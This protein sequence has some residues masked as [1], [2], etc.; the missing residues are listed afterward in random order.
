MACSYASSWQ[1]NLSFLHLWVK[2]SPLSRLD[3]WVY[4]TGWHVIRLYSAYECV[5]GEMRMQVWGGFCFI[6]CVPIG[7][8]CSIYWSLRK[9]I[10]LFFW[11]DIIP[12]NLSPWSRRVHERPVQGQE[13]VT[14]EE[15]FQSCVMKHN[16]SRSIL[17]KIIFKC[18]KLL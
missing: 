1:W 4:M 8:C 7:I 12:F 14:D 16:T 10:I 13:I 2:A 9:K 18:T 17:E 11:N 3:L 15:Y 6:F 5:C